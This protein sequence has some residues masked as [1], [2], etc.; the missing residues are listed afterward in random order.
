ALPLLGVVALV[1]GESITRGGGPYVAG[2]LM[3]VL[4]VVVFRS[5]DVPLFVEQLAVPVLL[6]GGGSLGFGLFRDLPT[7]G[8][9]V[10]LAL[11][12]AGLAIAVPRAWL[13]V[14]LGAVAAALITVA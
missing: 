11:V 13:R 2:I 10:A 9:A 5:R 14:L 12:A 4:A 7:E 3:L 6:V 8:A 1:G